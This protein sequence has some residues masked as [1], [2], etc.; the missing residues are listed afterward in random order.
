MH[1]SDFGLINTKKLLTRALNGK[2][3][4]PAFNFYNMETLKAILTAAEQTNSPIILAVSESALKYMGDDVLMGMI[5]GAK[6]KKN[7]VALHLDHGHSFESCKHAIDI[8]FSSVMF[9]G[10]ALPLSENIKTS[11]KIADYAHKHDVS[12]ETELGV[13][14]GI[15]DELTHSNSHFY[16]DPNIV[17]DF[18]KRTNTDSLAVAIGTSHGLY[19][20]KSENEKLRFDILQKI[21][22]NIPKTPLVLHGASSIPQKYINNINKYDG[23]LN[24]ARGTSTTQLKRAISMHITKINVDSDLRLA[25]TAAVREQFFKN[26]SIT[27]PRQYLNFAMDKMTQQCIDE[28]KNIMGSTNKA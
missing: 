8:G 5:A 25:F 20:R 24:N 6:Y 15:E 19:K 28:I 17:A 10:S 27:N 7:Q 3:A 13:L 18:V 14:A 23:K 2:Y 9:D 26:K 22:N 21:A 4:V 12:V 16:T 11:K 1:Y